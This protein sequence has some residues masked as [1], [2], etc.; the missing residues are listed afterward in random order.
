[1]EQIPFAIPQSPVATLGYIVLWVAFVMAAYCVFV[2]VVGNAQR[3]P[4]WIRSSVAMSHAFTAIMTVASMLMVYAFVSHDF[5]IKYVASNSDTT[6][7]IW[8]KVTAYW[9]ALEGS[10]MFWVFVLGL[11]SSVAIAQNVRKHA[12]MMGYVVGVIMAVQLFFLAILIYTRN[13]FLTHL[14][15]PPADGE[16]LNPLLQNYWMVIHPPT[17]YIGFVASTIPFAFGI[18]ALA[19]GRLDDMWLSSTR[20]WMFICFFF[21]SFGLILG[22]RWAYEELG[23]GGYWAWD[24]VENAGFLPWFT[25]TAFLHSIIVQ[26]QRGM[27][28]VWNLS[29]VAATF[30]LTILG[31]FMT[32]AGIVQSVHAFGQDNELAMY[33]TLFMA[34]ILILSTGLIVY[35]LPRLRSV[36]QL[37][38]FVSREGAFLVNNWILI[39]CATFV[40][41]GTMGPTI[42]EAFDGHRK[43]WG[44]EF[45][46]LFMVPLGLI[47]LLLAGAA[48]LLAWRQTTRARLQRQF[49]VPLSLLVGVPLALAIFFP[50]TRALSSIFVEPLRL[51]AALICFG[52]VAFTFSCIFQ[53][54]WRGAKVRKK[55]TQ[56]DWLSSLIGI[57]FAKRTR[58]GGYIIHLGVA[59]M[60]LGFA[61]KAYELRVDRSLQNPGDSFSIRE[62]NFVYRGTQVRSTDNKKMT[63][64]RVDLQIDGVD[65]AELYPAI[66]QYW[67]GDQQTTEVDMHH[68]AKEDVY[69]ILSGVSRGDGGK[70]AIANFRVYVNPLINFVWL[71]FGF[72]ALGTFLC[73]LPA[74][75][76]QKI[77]PENTGRLGHVATVLG[78]VLVFGISVLGLVKVASAQPQM[79]HSQEQDRAPSH[80]DDGGYAHR[81]QP[82]SAEAV[83][84]LG[85]RASDPVL[86]RIFDNI[87]CMCGGCKRETLDACRCG[88]AAKERCDALPMIATLM[89]QGKS[90]DEI[91][92]GVLQNFVNKHGQAALTKPQ[93]AVAWIAPL[94][95]ITLGGV[96][97]FVLGLGFVRKSRA[98]SEATE[99]HLS[100]EGVL[101]GNE[102]QSDADVP[103]QY[104]SQLDDE[105]AELED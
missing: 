87:T 13:P 12:D 85:E 62:Y 58:Y 83:Q 75:L 3:K 49:A 97:V 105:L 63:T 50:K 9:G 22:G 41:F 65:V 36:H 38:S 24:P 29:L 91:Y 30:F 28:K 77:E 40:V 86:P 93:T 26:K 35:R 80:A 96:L 69:I 90:D 79:E 15:Q 42:S 98:L 100:E 1:M 104:E 70:V 52:V 61:G 34:A 47:L 45:F 54:F 5:T 66:W 6:M 14:T 84:Y 8:Y 53:E 39:G 74:R 46:N 64:A 82:G 67:K 32:R 94:V 92:H 73:L 57:V 60:F 16:G 19:S 33:F 48:P 23:W 21:L 78:V 7:S 59:I 25:A 95:A 17:M 11:F 18:A 71:G 76:L 37:E 56:S 43:N 27:L 10:L 4:A 102:N 88:Y 72:L 44:P 20:L 99:S 2:G 103:S 51:P 89:Q 81:C 55:Q 101:S 31:T 68:L